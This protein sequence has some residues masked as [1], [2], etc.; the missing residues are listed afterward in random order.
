[1]QIERIPRGM[2]NTQKPT[3]ANHR[4][5]INCDLSYFLIPMELDALVGTRIPSHSVP[6]GCRPSSVD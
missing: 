1:M 5:N 2:E 4:E 3:R 6:P